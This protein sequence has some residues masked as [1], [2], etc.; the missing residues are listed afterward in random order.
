MIVTFNQL[1]RYGRL[2]NQMFQIASTI[3]IA[4]RSGAG[5]G[6]P[7][8]K[9]YDHKD[10]FNTTE[11]IDVQKYFKHAL[12]IYNGPVLQDH[13]CHWGYWPIRVTRSCSLIGHLQSE[14]YFVR[15]QDEIRYFFEVADCGKN[16]IYGPSLNDSIAVHVRRGDYDDNYHPR[17]GAEYYHK[18]LKTFPKGSRVTIFSDDI[19]DAMKM[20]SPLNNDYVFNAASTSDYMTD[21][22]A[23]CDCKHFIIGNSTFSWWP[24]WLS[25]SRG[26][27]VIAPSRW[28]G[29]AA[30]LSSV[31]I[32]CK[33]WEII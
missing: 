3:G 21:F 2:G 31:D 32:Y 12:P 20:L 26:K 9:N 27:R 25:Q 11:D 10:R 15:C 4:R 18:A 29:P 8:W 22:A 16:I 24:A 13:F 23:M 33:N 5:F 7:E 19:Q 6:F 14:K 28:F 30:N 1:G 17:L